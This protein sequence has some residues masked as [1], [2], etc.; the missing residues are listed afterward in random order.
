MRE[1]RITEHFSW[2]E[3]VCRH[4][5][6]LPPDLE[7]NVIATAEMAE[8]IRALLGDRPMR[9]SSWYRCP[10]H[11]AE[12]GGAKNSMHLQGKAIDFVVKD[13]VPHAVQVKCEALQQQGIIGGLGWYHGWTHADLGP[14]RSWR[15]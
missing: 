10:E 11:N 14:R 13:M 3:A 1:G 6:Q 9:I 7:P 8:R 2:Y 12:V 5:G 4:C 15:G